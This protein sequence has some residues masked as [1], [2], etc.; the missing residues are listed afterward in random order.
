[1]LTLTPHRHTQRLV[2]QINSL[3]PYRKTCTAVFLC[4]K[5]VTKHDTPVRGTP[6]RGSLC[7][8][9]VRACPVLP[10]Q[11]VGGLVEPFHCFLQSLLMDFMASVS[12]R[13]PVVSWS[14]S[15]RLSASLPLSFSS[16]DTGLLRHTGS[17]PGRGA[18]QTV[19]LLF[20]LYFGKLLVMDF[21]LLYCSHISPAFG[22]NGLSGAQF[23]L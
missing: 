22:K 3:S 18:A 6:K 8:A 15:R 5:G 10:G 13:F 19:P 12:V 4:A 1:M 11:L 2:R 21:V 23:L 16:S 9:P 14:I 17:V 7:P 20:R